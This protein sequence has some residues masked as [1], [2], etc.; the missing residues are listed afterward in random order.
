MNPVAHEEFRF[1]S[2]SL[3]LT[4]QIPVPTLRDAQL[5]SIRL[6][7]EA[8]MEELRPNF[9]DGPEEPACSCRPSPHKARDRRC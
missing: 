8:T 4:S 6:T 3:V 9:D 2:S 7:M 5:R 1:I